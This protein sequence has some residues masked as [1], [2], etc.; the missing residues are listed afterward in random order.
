MHD[1]ESGAINGFARRFGHKP[2]PDIGKK[3]SAGAAL[4]KIDLAQRLVGLH[5]RPDV[6]H[7]RLGQEHVVVDVEQH[8]ESVA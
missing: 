5:C 6:A 8:T 4:Q 2:S 3:F 1:Q 7:H